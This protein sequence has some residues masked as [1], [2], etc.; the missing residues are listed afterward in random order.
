MI[1]AAVPS[2]TQ[3]VVKIISKVKR[4]Q[5]SRLRISSDLSKEFGYDTVDLV[6]IIWELEKSFQIEI[7]DEVPLQT[8]GHFV[9]YVSN[10]TER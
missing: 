3:K 2:V 5:P 9:E 6:S 1:S 10:H 4:I 7:P 8:V